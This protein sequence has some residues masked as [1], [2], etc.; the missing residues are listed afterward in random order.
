MRFRF[1]YRM[2]TKLLII[3]ST[4]V[5]FFSTVL[6]FFKGEPFRTTNTSKQSS[7]ELVSFL[8]T[9]SFWSAID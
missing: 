1:Q 8:A 2:V 9:D 5:I 6:S 7:L 4:D 3:H